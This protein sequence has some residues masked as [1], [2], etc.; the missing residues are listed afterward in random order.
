MPAYQGKSKQVHQ[1]PRCGGGEQE[2][3][4]DD[5]AIAQASNDCYLAELS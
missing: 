5:N 4:S 2:E 3:G 1:E